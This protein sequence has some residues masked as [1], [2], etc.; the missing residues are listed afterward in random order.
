MPLYEGMA[1]LVLLVG[2][3]D[4]CQSKVRKPK[5]EKT[6]QEKTKQE[7]ENQKKAKSILLIKGTS[8]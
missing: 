7:K 1:M 4:Y 6:K 3:I 8:K 2:S 5:Q